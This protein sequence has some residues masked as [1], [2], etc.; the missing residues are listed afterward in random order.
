MSLLLLNVDTGRGMT[1]DSRWREE[2]DFPMARRHARARM[3]PESDFSSVPSPVCIGIVTCDD[4]IND[5]WNRFHGK[6][7]YLLSIF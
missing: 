4:T 6:N 1:R 5:W 2:L 3:F 7:I